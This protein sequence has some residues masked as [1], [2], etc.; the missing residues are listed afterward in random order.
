MLVSAVSAAASTATPHLPARVLLVEDSATQAVFTRSVLES[1]GYTVEVARNGR[2]GLIAA[3]RGLPDIVITDVRMP[4]MDGF[5][6]C[7]ALKDEFAGQ[8]P[9]VLLTS[10]TDAQDVVRSL[11]A[12]ADNFV[13]KPFEPSVLL[14]RVERTLQRARASSG[15]TRHEQMNAI[16]L[17]TIHDA[18]A[19]NVLLR[20]RDEQLARAHATLDEHARTLEVKVAQ[21]TG[22]LRQRE[23]QLSLVVSNLPLAV[24]ATDVTGAITFAEGSSLPALQRTAVPLVGRSLREL[25]EPHAA[26][27]LA[28]ERGMAGLESMA[29]IEIDD[30]VLELRISPSV[31]HNVTQGL[32][33]V[34]FDITERER[35]TAELDRLV[36]TDPLTAL[37]NRR[38]FRD[39]LSQAIRS[40][41]RTRGAVSV[42]FLDLDHFKKVNDVHGHQIGDALIR[43][44]GVRIGKTLRTI[45]TLGRLGGDEFAVVL[46]ELDVEAASLLAGR[47][48]AAL[49]Q[50]FFI[51][52]VAIEARVS[53]GIS[54][55]PAD[56]FD[57]DT[58][59]RCADV[60]MFV[61]KRSGSGHQVYELSLDEASLRRQSLA[62]DL[63]LALAAAPGEFML[64]Y[65]PIIEIATGTLRGVEALARWEH[66]ERGAIS[67][68]ECVALAAASNFSVALSD[69]VLDLAL[70]DFVSWRNAGFRLPVSVNLSARD[71]ADEDLAERVATK[72]TE[73]GVRPADL[74]FEIN[75]RA[76]I[77]DPT[78]SVMSLEKLSS[79]G[80]AIE[81]DD[82]GGGGASISDLARLPLTTVKINAAIVRGIGAAHAPTPLARAAIELA[83]ALGYLAVAKG[84]EGSDPLE[85]LRELGCDHAQGHYLARPMSASEVLEWARG[86]AAQS[87]SVAPAP[88][89]AE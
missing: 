9:V 83:H 49:A 62:A 70:G 65:Q 52:G 44:V 14:E 87:H 80:I 54:S 71:L 24:L 4:L 67:P 41:A 35:A 60:A 6:L 81:L 23:T 75:E 74:S 57:A 17:S 5:D 56:G 89:S 48:V 77:A 1:V 69:R 68:L 84:V 78:H 10:V 18:L 36:L 28:L 34:L 85:S 45:D 39:R 53:I 43:Q 58:L 46:P 22:A 51:D 61:A 16:L 63:V 47:I 3:R 37:P 12:G 64:V 25:F 66:P 7:R 27:L 82:F 50:P 21:A 79:L 86:H 76:L 42:L 29:R 55:S 38:L 33:C 59:L 31:Q 72:L 15:D 73:H 13:G 30:R 20:E 11:E 32:A 26:A 88:V 8:V 19:A 40:I 2:D